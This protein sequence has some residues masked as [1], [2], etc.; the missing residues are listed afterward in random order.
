[1]GVFKV[2]YVIGNKQINKGHDFVGSMMWLA[3]A[4]T[5]RLGKNGKLNL[6]L[7]NYPLIS[8]ESLET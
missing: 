1:M 8:L 3:I 2:C 7:Q 6:T 5:F 4:F